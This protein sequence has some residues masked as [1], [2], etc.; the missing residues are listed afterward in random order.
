MTTFAAS[1][2]IVDLPVG[3]TVTGAELFEAVQ[4][5]SGVGQ[6]VQLSLTN[7][8]TLGGL[9]TGGATGTILNKSSGSNYSTQ[10]SAIN[11]FVAVGTALATTGSATSIVAFVANQG[12]SSAQILNNTIT[13]TQIAN[14]AIGTNQLASSIAIA[15]TLTVGTNETV[16]GTLGVTGT[17]TFNGG[18]V[19]NGTLGITGNS[20]LT[21]T[22]GVVGNTLVTGTFGVVGTSRFTGA[23]NI[24]GTTSVTGV[25]SQSG[26]TLITGTFGVV[27]TSLVTGLFGVVG[28]SQ[29]TGTFNVVGTSIVTGLLTVTGTT[30]LQSMATGIVVSSGTGVL[31]AQGGMVL[32]NT[33]SPNGVSSTNDTTSLTSAYRSYFITFDNVV[34]ATNTTAFSM[35]VA[36]SGTNFISASYVSFIGMTGVAIYTSSSNFLLTG[37]T[38]TTSVATSTLYGVNGSILLSNPSGS[39][40]RKSISGNMAWAVATT[41]FS[42][43]GGQPLGWF[44]GNSSP[45]TGI[46]FL[47]SSG[48]IATGTIKIYGLT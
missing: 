10:F 48:N 23:F 19:G 33:L 21:G 17:A 18:I 6:S 30:T 25:L 1:V 24:V 46:N 29:H 42:A 11:T 12:I 5:T 4:T 15:S 26:T 22:L 7:L 35:Q 37:N 47:F 28:T 32:L 40:A 45:V 16:G 34:P 36:T 43:L 2:T 9:P 8:M 13:S 39:V 3:T 27:G 31:S 41:G 44:D 38:A 14:N 20:V